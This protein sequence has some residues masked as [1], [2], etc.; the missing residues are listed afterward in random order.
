MLPAPTIFRSLTR[1]TINKFGLPHKFSVICLGCTV[2]VNMWVFRRI[3]Y[4]I[5]FLLVEYAVLSA[6]VEWDPNFWRICVLWWR[7]KFKT[8]RD[9]MRLWG[10]SYLA[11]LPC[12][13]ADHAKDVAGA[14]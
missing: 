3:G 4:L 13:V 14:V 1:P 9:T 8:K 6:L 12:G 5:F 11:A 7:T 10:G 2:I